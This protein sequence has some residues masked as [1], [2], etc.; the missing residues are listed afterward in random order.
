MQSQEIPESSHPPHTRPS[1]HRD[2]RTPLPAAQL[3]PRPAAR[4][5][6]ALDAR[7]DALTKL[8]M[9]A[10]WPTPPCRALPR[11]VR[12]MLGTVH[13]PGPIRRNLPPAVVLRCR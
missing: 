8:T 4:T 6:P 3:D 10:A 1:R 5:R 7:P 13:I 12:E 11:Q 2:L 9:L